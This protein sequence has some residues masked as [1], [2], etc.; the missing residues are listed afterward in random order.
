MQ[1]FELGTGYDVVSN[2]KVPIQAVDLVYFDQLTQSSEQLNI[3][4]V[5][6]QWAAM[7][8]ATMYLIAPP[9]SL[10]ILLPSVAE[11]NLS[12]INL[13]YWGDTPFQS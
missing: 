3:S 9:N 6:E 4:T 10:S 1:W 11:N 13:R 7:V 8:M 5:V 2:T 12:S